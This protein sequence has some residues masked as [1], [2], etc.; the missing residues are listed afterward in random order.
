MYI[1][2]I[3]LN[4]FVPHMPFVGANS[5]FMRDNAR[6]HM[7]QLT[8]E[9]LEE[10]EIAQFEWPT[11][12]PNLN[13]FEQIWDRLGRCIRAYTPSVNSLNALRIALQEEWEAIQP[14]I[15]VL[16][17]STPSQL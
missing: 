11:C 16:I 17:D 9:F 15:C 2:G 13:P 10:V 3:L 7:A 4:Y 6:P 14:E 12:S 5:L 1:E 8:F